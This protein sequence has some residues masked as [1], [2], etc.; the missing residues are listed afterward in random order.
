[1]SAEAGLAQ[2]PDA[3]LDHE[4]R[5]VLSRIH[6]VSQAMNA[7]PLELICGAL[8]D[9]DAGRAAELLNERELRQLLTVGAVLERKSQ[10]EGRLSLA[11][12]VSA[13]EYAR[14]AD[15]LE[16]TRQWYG[17][18]S[19]RL[20][21]WAH[22]E[23]P[24]SLR[25]RYFSIVANA[26]VDVFEPPTYDQQM[27]VL[28]HRLEE[29]ERQLEVAN[30]RPAAHSTEQERY[31]EI[32]AAVERAAAEL[33]EGWRIEIHLERGAGV[34]H[35]FAPA[36]EAVKFADAGEGFVGSL[37]DAIAS[38]QNGIDADKIGARS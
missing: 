37:S 33:P 26:K 16:W 28:R 22:D 32:G 31:I 14:L 34:V 6:G 21:D 17:V 18:R 20:W 15:R 30:H 36:G 3:D 5:E 23:L 4:V 29:A 9:L 38:S 2:G 25:T 8:T 35:L 10:D 24:P 12:G 13:L 27:N 19:K 7:I 1:M 11:H